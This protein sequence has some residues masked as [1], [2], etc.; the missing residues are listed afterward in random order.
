LQ[1][2]G[3]LFCHI[4]HTVLT[5][6]NDLAPSDFHLFGLMKDGFRGKYF[7]DDDA[8]IVAVKR[9]HLEADR[10]FYKRG[11]QTFVQC[12]G[13]CVQSGGEYVKK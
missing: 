10:N 12:W 3:G 8:V 11:M 9:W 6:D 2:S 4:H 7:T 13:K 1:N 5:I